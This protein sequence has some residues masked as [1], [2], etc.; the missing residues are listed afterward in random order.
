MLHRRV[1]PAPRTA[2]QRATLRGMR[3]LRIGAIYTA[4]TLGSISFLLPL[5]WMISTAVKPDPQIFLF[6]PKWIPEPVLWGNFKA[7][8]EYFPF[9]LYFKNTT[10]ITVSVVLGQVFSA[11]FVAY[12]F[13]KLRWPGRDAVFILVLATM[14]LPGQITMIPLFVLFTRLGW[15]DTYLPLIV[16]SLF[17]GGAFNIFLFRQFFRSIPNELS[18]AARIDGCSEFRVFWQ[19]VLP[20]AKPAAATVAIF[21]FLW[22]WN[23]FLGPLIY[24]HSREKF[25]L[26]LGL[27]AFQQATTTQWNLLMAGSL[28]VML[29][30]LVLFF[31]LQR[32]FVQAV[33]LTGLKG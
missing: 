13:A 27:R 32:Y 30:V 7:A 23:D 22:T 15:I 5:A 24:L 16:P 29:P 19:I 20:L 11:A 10:L 33:M 4:L 21:A 28:I 1:A 17:G 31:L 3:W 18:D 12:G 26:A 14:M 2:T 8:I 9:W 6:P 25:T